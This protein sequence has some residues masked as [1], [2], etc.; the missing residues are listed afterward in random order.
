MKRMKVKDQ[1]INIVGTWGGE[2]EDAVIEYLKANDYVFKVQQGNKGP[3][4]SW[5]DDELDAK[6]KEAKRLVVLGNGVYQ[7]WSADPGA[8]LVLGDDGE[9]HF[10]DGDYIDKNFVDA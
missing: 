7:Q 10:F 4:L 1:F 8:V 9:M 5:G 3:S 6:Q 2:T